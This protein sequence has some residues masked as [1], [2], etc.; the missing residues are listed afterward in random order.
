MQGQNVDEKESMKKIKNQLC[1][2]DS[3]TQDEMTLKAP[4]DHSRLKRILIGSGCRLH[5]Y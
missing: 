5:D 3:M 1:I 4:I 2:I